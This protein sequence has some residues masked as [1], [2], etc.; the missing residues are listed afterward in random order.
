MTGYC[1]QLDADDAKALWAMVT[2]H[3]GHC[4]MKLDNSVTH[5][6]TASTTGVSIRCGTLFFQIV[7][8][9]S[10]EKNERTTYAFCS[11]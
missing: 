4:Q 8:F 5:L 7:I 10:K 11:N 9:T 1:F 2:Y 6:V 3:G